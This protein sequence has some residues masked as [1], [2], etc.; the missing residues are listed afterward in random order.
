MLI[1][2]IKEWNCKGGI[3]RELNVN[4]E[5]TMY[6]GGLSAGAYALITAGV[7]FFIGLL[8]GITRPFRCR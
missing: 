5:K 6:A 7:S 3:M 2:S 8:D 1:Y 4:E